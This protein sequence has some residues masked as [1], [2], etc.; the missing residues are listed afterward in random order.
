MAF[1]ANELNDQIM[2]LYKFVEGEC[3]VSFGLNLARIAG[4]PTTVLVNARQRA[5]VFGARL[6]K[7]VAEVN[8]RKKTMQRKR[9]DLI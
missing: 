8:K 7:H 5:D 9:Q 1:R 3:P 2:F 6:D 4:L